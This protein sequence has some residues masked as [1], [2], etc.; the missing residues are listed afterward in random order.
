MS[1]THRD[2]IFTQAALPKCVWDLTVE[3]MDLFEEAKLKGQK[4]NLS[5]LLSKPQFKQQYLAPLRRL[6]ESE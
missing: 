2:A 4:L 5:S 3:V 6:E 1:N